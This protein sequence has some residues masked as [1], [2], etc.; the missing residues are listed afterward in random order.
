VVLADLRIDQF[1]EMRLE[2]FVGA[3]FISPVKRE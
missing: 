2:T 3:F 1:E